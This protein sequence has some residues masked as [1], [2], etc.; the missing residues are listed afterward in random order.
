M[1]LHRLAQVADRAVTALTFA[2]RRD[3]LWAEYL[4]AGEITGQD[5]ADLPWNRER[6][7][8][9]EAAAHGELLAIAGRV[10]RLNRPSIAMRVTG[11]VVDVT[12]GWALDAR[13]TRAIMAAP[14]H[15]MIDGRVVAAWWNTTR[16]PSLRPARGRMINAPR[17]PLAITSGPATTPIGNHNG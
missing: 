16:K 9:R 11:A 4:S 3:R 13:R 10:A 5:H 6:R 17:R 1:I 12:G 14:D 15:V 7:K 2:G 8:N